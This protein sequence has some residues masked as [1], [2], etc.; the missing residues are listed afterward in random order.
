MDSKAVRLLDE[1]EAA[2][3]LHVSKRTLQGFRQKRVGP[4]WIR[5][6]GRVRYR[7]SDLDAYIDAARVLPLE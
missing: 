5:V 6:G 1:N 2:E 7:P 4:V 3:C